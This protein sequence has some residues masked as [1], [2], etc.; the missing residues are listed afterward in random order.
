MKPI[1]LLV[2]SEGDLLAEILKDEENQTVKLDEILKRIVDC[3]S[4]L[5]QELSLLSSPSPNQ[6][7]SSAVRA[8]DI[9]QDVNK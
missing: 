5:S 7:S 8:W 4:K 1:R 6:L 2:V 3:E 9:L